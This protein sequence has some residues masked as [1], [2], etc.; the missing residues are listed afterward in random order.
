MVHFA[1]AEEE[2]R[3]GDEAERMAGG[4]CERARVVGAGLLLELAGAERQHRPLGRC[5]VGDADVQVELIH[6][7]GSGQLGGR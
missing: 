2:D 4:I 5:Q 7:A 6:D 3:S 1:M